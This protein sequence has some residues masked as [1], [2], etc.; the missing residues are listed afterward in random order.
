MFLETRIFQ[1]CYKNIFKNIY[2]TKNRLFYLL[3]IIS[4]VLTLNE[5]KNYVNENKSL[6][7]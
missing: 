5:Q 4:C 7:S 6:L 3:I 2:K 1:Q